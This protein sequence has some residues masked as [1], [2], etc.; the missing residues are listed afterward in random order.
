MIFFLYINMATSYYQK[1]KENF[2]KKHVK[3]III[4]LKIKKKR[5]LSI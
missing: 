1:H 5:K 2:K 4:F 3:D